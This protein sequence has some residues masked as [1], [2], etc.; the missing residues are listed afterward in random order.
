MKKILFLLMFICFFSC[1]K[2]EQKTYYRLTFTPP[3]EKPWGEYS[4]PKVKL[5]QL[6][7]PNNDSLAISLE[8]NNA[9]KRRKI[10]TDSLDR[11]SKQSKDKFLQIPE[12]QAYKSILREEYTL[13]IFKNNSE[14]NKNEFMELIKKHGISSNEVKSFIEQKELVVEQ[15]PILPTLN[16]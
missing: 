6:N 9:N 2:S 10:A 8:I 1:E 12:E 7:L 3:I 14:F 13:L 16:N 11:V 15:I 4:E 5:E